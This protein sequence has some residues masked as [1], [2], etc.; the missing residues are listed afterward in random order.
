VFVS[1]IFAGMGVVPLSILVTIIVVRLGLDWLMK[2]LS[3]SPVH[4]WA[5]SAALLIL[6]LPSYIVME[7]GLQAFIFAGFGYFARRREDEGRVFQYAV[8][9]CLG[10]VFLQSFSYGLFG[11]KFVVL[12]AGM[13]LVT[14]ALYKF[15]PKT[16][17]EMTKDMSAAGRWFVQFCGRRTLEIYVGHLVL[18]KV[19]AV[20]AGVEGYEFMNWGWVW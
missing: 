2:I 10:Y 13:T 7:F 3:K 19:I 18:F 6:A 17:P 20:L 11:V 9:A 8:F 14:A 1:N 15:E 5:G 12:A 16:Y 4:L